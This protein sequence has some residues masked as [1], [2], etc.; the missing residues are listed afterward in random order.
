MMKRKGYCLGFVSAIVMVFTGVAASAPARPT[1]VA[2]IALYKGADRQQILE[3]GAKKE[4]K[5]I[6]YT[7]G[8]AKQAV[9]PQAVE[10][11]LLLGFG[12]PAHG[13][14]R[15]GQMDGTVKAIQDDTTCD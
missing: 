11:D 6:F 4:G 7:T 15:A 3:E 13:P 5:L 12:S 14:G 2:E 8:V 9:S 10:A 1:T